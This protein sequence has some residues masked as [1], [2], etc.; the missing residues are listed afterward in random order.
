MPT[1]IYPIDQYWIY[2]HSADDA[3]R[4]A[5]ILCYRPAPNHLSPSA[6]LHFH[7]DGTTIPASTEVS[8]TLH[9][10]YHEDQLADVIETLRREK[11]LNVYYNSAWHGGYLM[12]G[13][14]PIGEE[15]SP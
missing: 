3:N 1:V 10:R 9:L 13:R 5:S 12:T 4:S 2:H 14:E 8:G 15:E 11:P 6:Y 7:R